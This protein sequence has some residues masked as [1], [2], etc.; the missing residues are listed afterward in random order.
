MEIASLE[1][2]YLQL[3]SVTLKKSPAHNL[4]VNELYGRK[5][6]L[7]TPQRHKKMEEKQINEFRITAK[8]NNKQ[9]NKLANT[10]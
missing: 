9:T 2:I 10:A 7:K 8:E 4:T 1:E 3:Y 6:A 5:H